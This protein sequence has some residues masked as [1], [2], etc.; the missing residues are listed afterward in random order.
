MSMKT[1]VLLLHGFSGGPYE[2]EPLANFLREHTDWQIEVPTLSGHGEPEE[3]NIVGYTAF[4]WL[5]DAE[6][7]FVKLQREVDRVIVI[8]F[9]MGGMLAL[10][11]ASKYRVEKIV[12]LSA[13]MKYVALPQL[14][15]DI[16]DIAKEARTHG[17]ENSELFKRYQFKLKNVPANATV[18]F[19]K[20]VSTVRKEMKDVKAPVYI[21]QGVNDGIVP[22]KTAYQLFKQLPSEE[23]WLYISETG[24]HHICFSD[25]S[26][27]W[28]MHVLK[29]LQS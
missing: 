5:R 7:S 26:N 15:K 11:L 17:L 1:G 6:Y 20:V 14:A 12:L 4:H 29:K 24:K 9:S 10:H 27:R 16:W 8:G 13:A 21:V 19:M 18:Q 2:V 3:L 22:L 28:F 23:K 25:D